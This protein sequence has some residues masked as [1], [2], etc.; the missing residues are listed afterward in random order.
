MTT[1]WYVTTCVVDGLDVCVV[2]GADVCA[3]A[4]LDVWVV[5]G[6]DVCVVT[7]VDVCVVAGLDVCVVAE[8]DTCALTGI[9]TLCTTAWLGVVVVLTAGEMVG[10]KAAL[11]PPESRRALYESSAIGTGRAKQLAT[12]VRKP[13]RTVPVISILEP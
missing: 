8:L 9:E 2:A 3:V 12:S 7:G 4:G 1:C 6:L 13:T 10:S 11:P 5:T